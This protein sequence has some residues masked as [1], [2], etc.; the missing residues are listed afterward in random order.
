MYHLPTKPTPRWDAN[1]NQQEDGHRTGD[2]RAFPCESGVL[3][4]GASSVARRDDGGRQKEAG[5][6]QPV[7]DEVNDRTDKRRFELPAMTTP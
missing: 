5:L 6:Q 1:Q 7:A 4:D 3:V 2:E